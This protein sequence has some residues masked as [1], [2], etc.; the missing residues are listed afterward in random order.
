MPQLDSVTFVSQIFWIFLIFAV[1]YLINVE[2]ILPA[3][4][5]M[6]RIRVKKH[7]L[8]SSKSSL[9][10]IV[11][12]EAS[13]NKEQSIFTNLN[14]IQGSNIKNNI[15]GLGWNNLFVNSSFNLR[16]ANTGKTLAKG[17]N[18]SELKNLSTIQ[19]LRFN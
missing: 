6:L 19:I 14:D 15:K 4:G 5:S 7:G 10:Q 18:S 11:Q 17:E 13:S 2:H 16:F 1:F 9:L 12:T 8:D 3:I